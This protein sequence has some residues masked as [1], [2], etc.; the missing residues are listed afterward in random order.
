M[1]LP[2]IYTL[3]S[4]EGEGIG[5]ASIPSIELS[6]SLRALFIK[7]DTEIAPL[8]GAPVEVKWNNTF[9]KYQIIR[10]LPTGTPVTAHSFFHHM[11]S[12]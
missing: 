10:V 5:L 2:D 4:Q 11:D 8:E 7:S 3:Q 9:K 12:S 1:L 6:Q